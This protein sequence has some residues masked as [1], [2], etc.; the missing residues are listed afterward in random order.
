VKLRLAACLALV[1]L[2]ASCSAMRVAYNNAEPLVRFAAHDYFDLDDRQNE[3]FRNR[4]AQ[5]HA[6]HRSLELPAYAALLEDAAGK[7]EGG[8]DRSDVRWAAEAMRARYRVLV[9]KGVED[10]V[11]I[12]L[13]LTPAQL[14]ELERRFAK[15]NAK[16]AAE[17]VTGGERR[18]HRAR[19]KRMLGRFEDWTGDLSDAQEARIERFVTDQ[20]PFAALRLEDRRRW[21][22]A[23]V[24][25][26][27]ERRDARTLADG[28]VDLFAHSEAH[29]SA[30]YAAALA[31][32]EDGLA[33]LLVDIDRTLSEDQRAR[34]VRRMRRHAEDFRALSS[35]QTLA[36]ATGS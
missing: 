11:P 12:L 33:D 4:L 24:A 29:R 30:E 31:R 18:T 13:T 5:F 25:L 34:V 8:V 21:Q 6:W 15:A 10:A 26:I 14:E 36:G 32:W 19:L 2:L 9:A 7:V 22:R 16:Y 35:E 3:Q 1:A 28:L 20:A 17:Y 27:R 23:A